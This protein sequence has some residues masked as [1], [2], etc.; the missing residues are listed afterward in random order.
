VS[1]TSLYESNLD[2]RPSTRVPDG[3][4]G[5]SAASVFHRTLDDLR[6][7]EGDNFGD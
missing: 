4:D 1:L 2:I 6:A 5:D 3:P 7:D